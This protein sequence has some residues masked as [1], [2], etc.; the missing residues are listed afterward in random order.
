MSTLN[1]LIATAIDRDVPDTPD[2]KVVKSRGKLR[3][4]FVFWLLLFF[5]VIYELEHFLVN[6]DIESHIAF[7][8]VNVEELYDHAQQIMEARHQRGEMIDQ[9]FNIPELDNWIGTAYLGNNEYMLFYMGGSP[10]RQ[11]DARVISF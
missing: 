9:P 4:T 1:D 2:T 3:L 7:T 10:D 8:T 5:L 6:S 11:I